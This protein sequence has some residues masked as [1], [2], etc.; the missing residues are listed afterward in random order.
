M[1]NP[2]NPRVGA[3]SL[4][5]QF[6]LP[7]FERTHYPDVFARERLAAKIDLPEARIQVFRGPMVLGFWIH[8]IAWDRNKGVSLEL[9]LF[10]QT[11]ADSG[12]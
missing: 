3:Y 11:R 12:C 5:N 4:E 6:T 7:E 9:Y 1:W 10:I 2:F 8:C